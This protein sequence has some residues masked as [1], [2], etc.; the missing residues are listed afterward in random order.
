MATKVT[1]NTLASLANETTHLTELNQNFTTIADQIDLLVSRDGESPNTLTAALDINSQQLIN[2]IDAT[3]NQEPATYGQVVSLALGS[4]TSWDLSGTL[5]VDIINEFTSAA[6]VTVEGVL[7]KDNEVTTDIINEKTGAA[8]VTLDGVLLKDGGATMTALTTGT[9]VTMTGL[10]TLGDITLSASSPE[11]LGS[12]T[13]GSLSISSNTA[14]L[15]ASVVLYGDTHASRA[16]DVW[17]KDDAALTLEYDASATLWDFQANDITTT[18]DISGAAGTLTGDLIVDRAGG[19]T[20]LTLGDFTTIGNDITLYLRTTGDAVIAGAAGADLVFEPQL[21]I[22]RMRLSSAGGLTIGSPTG[23]DQGAGTL[24]AVNY[25]KDGIEFATGTGDLLAANNLSD[26]IS[27]ATS[28]TNLDV[29]QAGT[30]NSTDVTLTGTP[31][32]ITLAGQVL[33]RNA[34]DLTADVTGDLPVADGGTGASDAATAR[35]NLEINGWT[36]HSTEHTSVSSGTTLEWTSIPSWATTLRIVFFNHSAAA[37]QDLVLKLGDSGGI[38]S[39][40]YNGRVHDGTSGTN[41]NTYADLTKNTPSSSITHGTI[42]LTNITGNTWGIRGS[43]MEET[44]S[45]HIIVGYKTTSG[46]LDRA[47]LSLSGGTT[48]DGGGDYVMYYM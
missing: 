36:K 14:A 25:Y 26:V 33:T 1:L 37:G 3:T 7:L 11:I 32:Y 15:G 20:A 17:F 42:D 6:G 41:W 39:T 44:L 16:G 35:S 21:S 46:T 40:G 19:G 12:D 47:Q 28:R 9:T 29:D 27:A 23:G 22:E 2:L 13:N 48:F 10:A 31:D 4:L 38:E 45:M 34:I 30:D 8:G 5:T 24:N 43:A 18:G